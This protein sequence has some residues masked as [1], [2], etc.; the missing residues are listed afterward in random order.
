MACYFGGNMRI[1]VLTALLAMAPALS[2]QSM[3]QSRRLASST[4]GTITA[5]TPGEAFYIEIG[6]APVPALKLSRPFKSSMKGAMGLPFAFSI[7]STLLVRTGTSRDGRWIY[8]QPKDNAFSPSHGLL[9]SVIRPG[10]SV[11]LRVSTSGEREWFV[12]N[13]V[14]NGFT[15]IWTRRV[16]DKDPS[17]TAVVAGVEP[18]GDPAERLLFLGTDGDKVRVREESISSTGV[19]RD[20]FVFPM[21]AKGH[22]SGAIKG[23]EF[24]FVATPQRALFTIVRAMG[25]TDR[26]AVPDQRESDDGPRTIPL[27]G[28]KIGL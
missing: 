14:Y 28:S 21:D 8:F 15:T 24:T 22:G 6:V 23:A 4:A 16:K 20:D 5:V 10:D 13:S 18:D 19:Q 27:S 25:D 3:P 26:Q 7:D 9:G 1:I 17:A 2:A 12:D 11:G